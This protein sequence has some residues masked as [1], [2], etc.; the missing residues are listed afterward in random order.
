MAAS[1]KPDIHTAYSSSDEAART[2]TFSLPAVI[3]EGGGKEEGEEGS[4]KGR[5][6]GGRGG[7]GE[8]RGRR[9]RR[10]MRRK[11]EEEREEEEREE[12]EREEEEG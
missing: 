3:C 1:H 6:E 12:E 4:R 8:G 11:G 10:G 2:N 5:R 7:G 9:G